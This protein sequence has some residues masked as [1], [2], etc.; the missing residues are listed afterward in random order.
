MVRVAR[1]VELAIFIF[2]VLGGVYGVFAWANTIL[3]AIGGGPP[4]DGAGAV[5]LYL[6]TGFIAWVDLCVGA[7]IL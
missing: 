2:W 5:R 6:E 4:L 3:F 7:G 1:A